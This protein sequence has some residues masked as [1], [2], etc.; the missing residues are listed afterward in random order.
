MT[1]S[2]N[3]RGVAALAAA[4]TAWG[5]SGVPG[6]PSEV[7]LDERLQDDV[8]AGD[9]GG[10]RDE[11]DDAEQRLVSAHGVREEVDGHDAQPVECVEDQ[12]EQ[13]AH[14]EQG[15]EHVYVKGWAVFVELLVLHGRDV[16]D[17][18]HQQHEDP[19]AGQPGE[20]KPPLT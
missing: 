17:V 4:P 3:W 5:P 18:Q 7:P 9:A 16:D 14:P 11:D 10:Q 15:E 13:Q 19:E 1:T 6:S 2:R 8:A 20:E 12:G